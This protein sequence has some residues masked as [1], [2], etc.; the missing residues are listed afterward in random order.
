MHMVKISE[1]VCSPAIEKAVGLADLK[2]SH[3]HMFS[4]GLAWFIWLIVSPFWVNFNKKNIPKSK[5]IFVL[6]TGYLYWCVSSSSWKRRKQTL[7]L[8][9]EE[10]NNVSDKKLSTSELFFSF[11]VVSLA[12]HVCWFTVYVRVSGAFPT[13]GKSTSMGYPG[14]H[15]TFTQPLGM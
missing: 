7:L 10:G 6:H 11:P 9:L 2:S 15:C 5:L 12:R 13:T 1:T 8:P 14:T 3:T 4:F